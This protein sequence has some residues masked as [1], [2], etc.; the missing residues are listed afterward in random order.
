MDMGIKGPTTESNP[1]GII[2]KTILRIDAYEKVMGRAVFTDDLQFHD[3]LHGKVLRSVLPHARIL[4]VDISRA[5]KLKGVKAVVTG[6]DIP[7][8]YGPPGLGI[9]DQPF[10]AIDRVRYVGEPVVA[11]AAVDEETAQEALEIIRIDYEKLP[12]VL[13]PILSMTRD[14]PLLHEQLH[15]YQRPS[16]IHPVPNS[17]ICH[18]ARIRRGDVQQGFKESD[19]IFE[20]SFETQRVQHCSIEPH[21]AIAQTDAAGR[22]ILWVANDS[23][24]ACRRELAEA[25]NVP[26]TKVRVLIPFMGGGFGGKGGLTI[27]PVCVALSMKTNGKPVKV[28]W[29]RKE[30]FQSSLVRHPTSINLKIGVKRDGTLTALEERIIW[31]TGAYSE[32]GPT[33]CS[34]GTSAASGPYRIPHLHIDGYCVYTNKVVSGALRG[35]GIPQVTWAIESQIDII[36]HE[37]DI[38]P[39]ELRLKNCLKNGDLSASGQVL[40]AVGVEEC[41]KK[42][43]EKIGWIRRPNKKDHGFGMAAMHKWQALMASSALIKLNEDGTALLSLG[44]VEIGQGAHT[45]FSQ[46][47]SEELGIP[48]RNIVIA[49]PDTDYTPYDSSTT[50]SRSTFMMGN[51]VKRAALDAKR[52]LLALAAEKLEVGPDDLEVSEGR[53]FVKGFPDRGVENERLAQLSILNKNG[54]ILGRGFFSMPPKP[55]DRETGQGYETIWMYGAHAVEV[56]VDRETGEVTVL[57]VVAAHDVGKAI[58]PLNCEGQ[59]EG[60]VVMGMGTSF[61][62]EMVLEEGKVLNANLRDYKIP[63][64][65]NVPEIIPIL[66]EEKHPEGPYG[67]KGLGEPALAPTAPAIA[68]AIYDAIGVRITDL[69]ITSEKTLKVLTE[70]RQNDY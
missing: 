62:E 11:V 16:T 65:L 43:A 44:T 51:A 45:I 40:Q 39:L 5:I 55:V 7:A 47:V 12:P 61:W 18:H 25:L 15:N 37:L 50:G 29:S 69:P 59:I 60:S 49:S 64:S 35:F 66:V 56:K 48:L 3:M 31:D 10:L 4:D 67:A 21:T 9:K 46:I 14:T 13:D 52:Q 42:V 26:I 53:V 19:L 1:K 36:A 38:D 8:T 28:S 17:N 58:N 27:E 34:R 2:G 6:R 41:L 33:I 20:N 30:E 54:P 57:R 24:F 63:T 22:I 68:N 70:H 23:P 32:K